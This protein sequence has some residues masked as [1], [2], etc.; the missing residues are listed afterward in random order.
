MLGFFQSRAIPGVEWVA[1]GVYHRTIRMNNTAGIIS[2]AHAEK[3]HALLLTTVLSDSRDLMHIVERVR[4]TFD[5]DADMGV[6]HEVFARDD[7][8]KNLVRKLHGLRLPGACDPFEVA[9]RVVTGQQISIKGARTVIGRI[10]AKAGPVFESADYP[11]LTHFFPTAHELSSCDLGRIGMPER[12]VQTIQKLAQ[13]VDQ[14][15]LSFLVNGSL[16]NF[17]EPLTRIPGIG[18]WTAQCIAMRALGEPDAFPAADLG[19]IKALHQGDERPTLKQILKRAENWRPWRAYAAVY[20]W[21][22]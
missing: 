5:L 20:L 21:H 4:R 3:E 13:A 14:G 16:G 11:Q 19:I 9:I 22:R 18:D 17:I 10:A 2:V 1:D 12:R 8:L 15:E 7:V 6:I